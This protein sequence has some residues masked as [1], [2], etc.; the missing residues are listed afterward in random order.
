[1]DG[2]KRDTALLREIAEH[3]NL[4]PA[5]LARQSKVAVTT[6]N[7]P[8]NGTST[9]RLSQPT[10]EKLKDAFPTFPGWHDYLFREL[11]GSI[12]PQKSAGRPD[13]LPIPMLEL[14]YGMGGTF[15]D[16]I[17]PGEVI[18]HFP[19][20]FVRMFTQAPANLLCFSHG[21]GDS[22]Y[23]TIGDRDVLLIDRS[24]TDVTLNDQIW[25]M[26]VGGI[27]MVK[28]V[29]I[30]GGKVTLMSDNENVSDYNAGEGELTMVGR[31]IAVVRRV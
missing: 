7:R 13:S 10:L 2:L 12:E 9:H 22:M 25:V 1:M 8:F 14:G 27:G 28:R 23:P 21:I 24:R 29:R 17:D 6:I 20:A 11:T 26:S 16:G 5:A 30:A 15:L 19:R 31:V 18:E 4:T 3:F